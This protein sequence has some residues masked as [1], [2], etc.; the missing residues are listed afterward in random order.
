MMQEQFFLGLRK[1]KGVEINLFIDRFD[2]NPYDI[3]D[4]TSVVLTGLVEEVDGYIRLTE[5]GKP[6]ANEVFQIFV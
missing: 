2:V 3:F 1:M 6:L 5:K 4:L